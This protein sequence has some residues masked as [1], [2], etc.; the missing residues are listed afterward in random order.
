MVL[1]Y[2]GFSIQGTVTEFKS[3][4]EFYIQMNSPKVLERISKLSVKLQDCYANAAIQE[5]YVAIR[6]EVC[7]ARN[8]VDQ[9]RSHWP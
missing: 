8:S 5:Q 9:V 3:P 4:S 1:N 6:G 7:V 2:C